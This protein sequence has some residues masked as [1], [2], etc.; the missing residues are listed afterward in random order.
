MPALNSRSFWKR[1][2]LGL[3]DPTPALRLLHSSHVGSP[4]RSG[5]GRWSGSSRTSGCCW[6]LPHACPQD[7]AQLENLGKLCKLRSAPALVSFVRCPRGPLYCRLRYR[8]GKRC[9]RFRVSSTV[10][11]S[12]RVRSRGCGT[13]VPYA[14]RVLPGPPHVARI[15]LPSSARSPIRSRPYAAQFIGEA[16]RRFNRPPRQ[17]NSVFL[18]RTTDQALLPHGS[19][20]CRKPNVRA[21]AISVR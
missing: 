17:H 4:R 9:N 12:Q 14:W 15:C 7:F 20:S 2:L 3:H 8:R 18:R 16:Q 21:A 10:V 6:P 5:G 19:A 13:P 11:S 1:V